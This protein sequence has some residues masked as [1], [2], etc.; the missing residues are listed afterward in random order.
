MMI[1]RLGLPS[2]ARALAL[3]PLLWFALVALTL[4]YHPW[5]GRFFVFPVA[6]SAALWGLTLRAPAVAWSVAALAAITV[7]LSL[8]HYVEKPSGTRLLERGRTASVWSLERWQV[9]SQHDPTLGSVLRFL[10]HEVPRQSSIGLA[11]GANDFGYPAFGPALERRVELVPLGSNG[12]DVTVEWLFANNER[13]T[14]IDSTCWHAVLRSA[15]GTIFRRRE[16]C[17]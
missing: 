4:T 2:L 15:N 5:Q 7:T 6:L 13:S 1:K 12:R 10:D 17:R 14:E 8:V 16:G 11:L 3:A 9:Q